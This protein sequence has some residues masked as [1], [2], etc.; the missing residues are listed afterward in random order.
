MAK[1]P[2][3]IERRD[4]GSRSEG[5]SAGGGGIDFPADDRSNPR[6]TARGN[7]VYFFGVQQ[8][9]NSAA[10]ARPALSLSN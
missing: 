1:S 6:Q 9:C 5:S 10:P 2:A 7:F 4:W 8:L 3:L